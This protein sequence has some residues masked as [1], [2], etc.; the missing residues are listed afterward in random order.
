MQIYFL[1]AYY[2]PLSRY[3]YIPEIA[4]LFKDINEGINL[5]T[6]F[7]TTEIDFFQRQNEIINFIIKHRQN[8][9]ID[10]IKQKTF[11]LSLIPAAG[12]KS[13]N[14]LQPSD[15]HYNLDFEI[16]RLITDG[17]YKIIKKKSPDTSDYEIVSDLLE[18]FYL[19]FRKYEI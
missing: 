11:P 7:P 3:T 15:L 5:S 10:S 12:G 2:E 4:T 19:V 18:D 8:N 17:M 9:I 16:C 1:F 13:L 6:N 14:E